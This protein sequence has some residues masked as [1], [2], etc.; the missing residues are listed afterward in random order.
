MKSKKD[1]QI[2]C[3]IC[4]RQFMLRR[5]LMRH[6]KLHSNDKPYKCTECNK[7]FIQNCQLEEHFRTH[8]GYR[9]FQCTICDKDFSKSSYLRAHLKTHTLEKPYKCNLCGK[10]FS[11]SNQVTRHKRIHTNE[12]PYSCDICH[13]EF[14]QLGHLSTHMKIHNAK[15]ANMCPTCGKGF[16]QRWGLTRHM[17]KHKNGKRTVI[18]N[19]FLKSPL[20]KF[21]YLFTGQD[22]I[23]KK[24]LKSVDPIEAA[25]IRFKCSICSIEFTKTNQLAKHVRIHNIKEYLETVPN[26]ISD[27]I[28]TSLTEIEIPDF[29]SA[30]SLIKE[31]YQQWS[32]DVCDETVVVSPCQN[33]N[34]KHDNSMEEDFHIPCAIDKEDNREIYASDGIDYQYEEEILDDSNMIVNN[35]VE[36]FILDEKSM[37]AIIEYDI[38]TQDESINVNRIGLDSNAQ[39]SPSDLKK[40]VEKNELQIVCQICGKIFKTVSN[41]NCHMRVHSDVRNFACDQCPNTYKYSTQLRNHMRKHSGQKPYMCRHD[42]CG[43]CFAQVGQLRKHNRIHTGERPYECSVCSKRFSRGTHL[44]SHQKLHSGSAMFECP[45]CD[46]VYTQKPQLKIHMRIHTGVRE[47]KCTHCDKE[48]F[49]LCVLK[50]HIKTHSKKNDVDARL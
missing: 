46:K 16:T 45:Q 17:A 5:M 38:V 35:E 6:I 10:G 33:D 8:T 50:K 1:E 26:T 48:F 43:K 29:I 39:A 22:D 41:L 13:K 37:D 11:Q 3:E 28:S 21:R 32:S 40:M 14:S 18:R 34:H 25:A 42:K 47:F 23:N 7:Q 24:K 15:K 4:G 19:I 36:I 27:S 12:K 30:N 44:R 2:V 31:E 20:I 9:P 49:K